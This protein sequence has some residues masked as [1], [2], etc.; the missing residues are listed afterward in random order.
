MS[1]LG[2]DRILVDTGPIV[3]IFN[4]QDSFH[5]TCIEA[6]GAIKSPLHTC[7]PVLTEAAYLL[8][9]SPRA[10]D[11]LLN[12]LGG[13]LQLLPLDPA[14][15]K[16]IADILKRYENIHPQLADAALVHLAGREGIDTIFTLDRRDFSVYRT[17]RGRALR[18]I[19]QSD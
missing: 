2:R 9:Y 10:V 17:S 19:P 12:S 13:F 5:H 18:I 14:D 11:R 15:A 3:A 4:P 7:W 1:G 8:A 6:L 16:A